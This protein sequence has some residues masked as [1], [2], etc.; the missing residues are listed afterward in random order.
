MLNRDDRAWNWT[1]PTRIVEPEAA[2]TGV[3][4]VV[5]RGKTAVTELGR[6]R[7]AGRFFFPGEFRMPA[8]A[9]REAR[10][11]RRCSTWS[12]AMNRRHPI[13]RGA[14]QNVRPAST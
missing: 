14:A 9:R 13:G 7:H 11:R 4:K 2:L 12:P 1:Q 10:A 3:Q 6:G 8:Q 5:G